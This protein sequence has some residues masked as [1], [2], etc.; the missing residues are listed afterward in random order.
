MAFLSRQR[1]HPFE[2]LKGETILNPKQGNPSCDN[3]MDENARIR[4]VGGTEP[5]H[6]RIH[7]P[8]G[9]AQNLCRNNP[10]G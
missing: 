9:R 10:G 4:G 8:I 5:A 7:H 2:A 6:H 1:D 3:E